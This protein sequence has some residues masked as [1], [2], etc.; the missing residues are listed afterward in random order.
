[1]TVNLAAIGL[2]SNLAGTL[3]DPAIQLSRAFDE[4]AAIPDTRLLARSSLYRSVAV[5]P[6]GQ[7]VPQ[8]D[9]C[10]AA[11][12]VE[13]RLPPH[14][15]LKALQAIETAHGR[16]REQRWT[17]RSLDLDLLVF[18]D[19]Q[20]DEPG[21]SVPHPRIAGRN[22]VLYPLRDIAPDLHIPR[23]GIVRELADGLDDTGLTSWKN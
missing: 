11:A 23:L 6:D 20:L 19:L 13:T 10:N 8:P 16:R 3:G 22:F 15:L 12:L 21:I 2:G 18:G 5:G 1:M 9:F 14:A 4:I 17:A 7:P